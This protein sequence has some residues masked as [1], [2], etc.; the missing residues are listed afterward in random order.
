MATS[1]SSSRESSA[2]QGELPR[3]PNRTPPQ[4]I[5][6]EGALLGSMILDNT[7]IGDVLELVR[8]AEDFYKPAHG[9][10]FRVLVEMYDQNQTVDMVHLHQRLQDAGQLEQVGGVDYLVELAES[11]PHA[12]NATHYAELVR[13]KA[14]LRRLIDAAGGILQEAYGGGTSVV[15]QIEQAEQAIFQLGQQSSTGSASP[16]SE[17]LHELYAQLE[18]QEGRSV[19]GIESGFY[20]LDE[21]TSGLHP[22]EMV[23]LA[24][25]PSM[26]KTAFALNIAEQIAIDQSQPVGIFSLEMSK[27]QLAQRL[28]CSRSGVDAHKLRRNMLSGDDFALLASTVGHL[29]EAPLYIDDTPG[30]Q[31]LGLRA[32]ARRLASRYQ[33]K[34]LV[35]DYLQLMN[36]PGAESRQ[37]EVSQLSQGIKA[38]ARELSVPVICLSQLNRAAESRE[39]H[40]PRMSDLRESGSIEQDADV[41]L[42]LH[43][44]D[45]YHRGDPDHEDSNVA[46]LIVAKQ[47]NGP[48][49]TVRLQFN[50]E[51]T[52][53]NNLA[54]QR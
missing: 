7:V 3:L 9:V 31:L 17:L 27:E 41:V 32:R 48:T 20:E 49:G 19:T 45:Y 38:L 26:G 12:A 4:A 52:R 33:I 54:Q 36:A 53:F 18:A 42:M 39:G 25:R 46:E 40:R 2:S 5:E 21:M 51:T 30:M 47:R 13:D 15:D 29:S 14:L 23:V 28:L 44:E 50:H 10:I 34:A 16:L 6:A 11:V 24:A 8:S 35:V 37:Q 43:R 1:A 22:G